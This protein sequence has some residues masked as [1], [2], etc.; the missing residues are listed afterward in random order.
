[1]FYS[2]WHRA[3][4]GKFRDCRITPS[5]SNSPLHEVNVCKGKCGGL[6]MPLATLWPV[7][8][9]LVIAIKALRVLFRYLTRL[10]G[11]AGSVG[12]RLSKIGN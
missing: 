6:S 5:H 8:W 12:E 10:Y 2:Y 1:M 11:L 7:S 9:L 3:L 4:H